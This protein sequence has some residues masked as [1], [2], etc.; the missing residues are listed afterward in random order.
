LD[1]LSSDDFASARE[2]EEGDALDSWRLKCQPTMSTYGWFASWTSG[3]LN[4]H[5]EHHDFPSMPWTRLPRLRASAPEY[6]N[7][8]T[9]MDSWFDTITRYFQPEGDKWVYACTG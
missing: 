9:S 8:L 4:L 2:V 5:V 1:G 7:C 6:Y 3:N